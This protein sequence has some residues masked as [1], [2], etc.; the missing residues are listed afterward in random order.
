MILLRD[1]VRR[2][3]NRYVKK[4]GT[5]DPFEIAKSLNIL[6]QFGSLGDCAGCYMPLKRHKYIFINQ[7]IPEHMQRLTMAHELGHAIM[8]PKDNCYFLRE[9]TDFIS[10]MEIEANKFAVELLITDFELQEYRELTIE[11]IAR[12]YGYEKRLIELRLNSFM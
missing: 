10:K 6:W 12:I 9:H 7:D 2:L 5:N 1:R 4:F 8:H 11:Q 3:A